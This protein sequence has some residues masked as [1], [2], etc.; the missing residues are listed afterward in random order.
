ME[1]ILHNNSSKLDEKK[2]SLHSPMVNAISLQID[3]IHK[4]TINLI[5]Y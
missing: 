5:V 3:N 2:N 1:W 4:E